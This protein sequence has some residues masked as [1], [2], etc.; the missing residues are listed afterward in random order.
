MRSW[1]V[2]VMTNPRWLER[3]PGRPFATWPKPTR[4]DLRC[5]PRIDGCYDRPMASATPPGELRTTPTYRLTDDQ[6]ALRDAVRVL[7]DEK[8]APRAAEI[9]RTAEF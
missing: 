1:V 9:D 2:R 4:S 6:A 7:A 3:A 5:R 8:I